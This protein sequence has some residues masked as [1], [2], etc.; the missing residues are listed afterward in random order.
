MDTTRK[1]RR[2]FSL[3]ELVIVIVILGIIA[4]IAIPR[5]SSGSRNASE[6]ALRANLQ[7]LRNAVDW[8]YSEHNSIFPGVKAAGGIF[9]VAGSADAFM[10]Q[11]TKYSKADGTV[12]ETKDPAF[13][14]GP[15]VRGNFP[16]IPVGVNAGL[17]TVSVVVD[18]GPLA[19][20]EGDGTGWKYSTV[21]GMIVA[22]TAEIA[23]NGATYDTF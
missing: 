9:G 13:P 22:N 14:L 18:A 7:T 21:T 3:V 19:G 5:I 17:A 12:S 6:A 11:L 15:Y 10:N 2:A 16:A 23:S 1:N 8:Y 4:A 20:A